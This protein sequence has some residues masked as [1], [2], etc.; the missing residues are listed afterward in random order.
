MEPAVPKDIMD[1]W[2]ERLRDRARMTSFGRFLWKRFLDDRLFQAAASLAYTTVFA[3]VPLAIVAFGVLSAFPAFE[4]WKG[5]LT[6]FVFSNFVPGAARSVQDFINNSLNDAGTFTA[7]G[8]IALVIS[9]LITLHSVEQTFNRVWRVAS[10][11]PKFTRFLIYWT[12]LTLG[13]MFA[14]ASMATAAYVFALPLFHTS[15][16][17][18]VAHAAWRLAPML[19]EFAAIVLIYRVVPQHSVRLRHAVPGALLAVVS[20]ELVK[21]GLG[22]YLGNFQTYQRI[23]GALSALPILLL[24]I[25]LS[26]VSV[27]L[28]ATLSAS[29]AAFR[30]QPLAMRLPPGHEFYALLRLLGRFQLARRDGGGLDEDTMLRLEP[31]LTDALQQELLCELERIRLLRRDERGEWL[32][33]RDLDEVTLAELYESCQLRLAV[34]DQPLPCRNDALGRVADAALQ[35]LRAPLRDHLARPVGA[36]YRHLP[37]DTA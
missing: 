3:L 27:L 17:K 35:A 19:V 21:W 1:K 26:W 29:I 18:W 32:L 15:E 34:D 11:R 20:L 14:A 13:T 4:Q 5:A 37:G 31:M 16:G 33:A 12:V 6:D 2:Q 30:Y 7:A 8:V 36:I 9:L 28:G 23:Y 24:W 22:L 10:A 25:Y